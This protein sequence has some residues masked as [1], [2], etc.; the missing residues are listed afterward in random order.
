MFAQCNLGQILCITCKGLLFPRGL[1]KN[2]NLNS[3]LT[4]DAKYLK[5]SPN[6]FGIV[7]L[8]NFAYS[9]RSNV[10]N[11]DDPKFDLDLLK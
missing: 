6:I 7:R 3:M 9:L 10:G 5:D 2:S 4:I 1:S 11:V 8:I